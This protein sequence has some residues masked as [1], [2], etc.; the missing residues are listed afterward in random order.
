[1]ARGP[2]FVCG[3]EDGPFQRNHV[4][5]RRSA[6]DAWVWLCAEPC[7]LEFT[8]LQR[9]LGIIKP[10]R[11]P[12]D[13]PEFGLVGRN[14]A[15]AQGSIS[16]LLQAVREHPDFDAEWE[17]YLDRLTRDVT[18]LAA[19][20]ARETEEQVPLPDPLADDGHPA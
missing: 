20:V 7:H 1:M 13:Q 16:Q 4:A 12:F 14:V 15:L 10:G 5:G 6:P 9:S 8:A 3:S 2:C 11:K 19:R 18:D 17:P